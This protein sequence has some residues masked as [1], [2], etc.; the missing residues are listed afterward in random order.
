MD[1]LAAPVGAQQWGER[2]PWN[3]Y[4]AGPMIQI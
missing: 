3:M 1:A 2:E 4:L